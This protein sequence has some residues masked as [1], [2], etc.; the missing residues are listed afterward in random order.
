MNIIYYLNFFKFTFL[1]SCLRGVP[2]LP[3]LLVLSVN[4]KA[5][6]FASEL[7]ERCHGNKAR[8]IYD[9]WFKPSSIGHWW[10]FHGS[11]QGGQ[12]G[13]GARWNNIVVRSFSRF[14]CVCFFAL[15]TLAG[16]SPGSAAWTSLF[17]AATRPR[18]QHSSV[19][20]GETCLFL[21]SNCERSR[22][23]F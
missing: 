14:V 2:L 19:L 3:V 13:D 22:R 4:C 7:F 5:P 15:L 17:C 10:R 20:S 6:W 21:S 8:L 11:L 1:F 16:S 12:D 18:G 9:Q 23:R